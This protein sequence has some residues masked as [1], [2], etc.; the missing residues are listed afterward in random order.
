MFSVLMYN[1]H[2][3][4]PQCD[5]ISKGYYMFTTIIAS[6]VCFITARKR[7]PPS[8][9]PKPMAKGAY[10]AVRLLVRQSNH[11]SEDPG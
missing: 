11:D 10:K 2:S 7:T 4:N 1:S 9:D 5:V 6:S 3:N 8:R